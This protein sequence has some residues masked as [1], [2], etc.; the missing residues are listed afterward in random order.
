MVVETAEPAVGNTAGEGVRYGACGI[1]GGEDGARTATRCIPAGRAPRSI[2]TKETGLEIRPGDRL[3]LESGGGGGWATRRGA[4][5]PPPLKTAP[6][7][8]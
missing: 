7:S 3:V 6:T 1:L 4:T 5:P 2:R 8:L